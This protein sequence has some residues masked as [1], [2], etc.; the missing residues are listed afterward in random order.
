[1]VRYVKRPVD[2]VEAERKALEQEIS[3][4]KRTIGDIEKV[5]EERAVL[6]ELKGEEKKAMLA[7]EHP[8]LAAA[9][10]RLKSLLGATNRKVEEAKKRYKSYA[11]KHPYKPIEFR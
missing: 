5:L 2:K 6:G 7:F 11:K 9:G 4:H 10:R 8:R 1:M 3:K